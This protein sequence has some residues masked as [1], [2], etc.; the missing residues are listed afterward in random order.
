MINENSLKKLELMRVLEF[1]AEYAQSLTA[2][3]KL[4]NTI[5]ETNVEKVNY[6][7]NQT[8]E[9]CK[10]LNVYNVSPGFNFDSIKEIADKAKILSVLSMKELLCV[11]RILSTSRS[12]YNAFLSIED[13]S[14]VLL[15]QMA[16][17][18]YVNRTIEE[19][20]DFAIL[21]EDEM[22]DRASE[23]LYRIRTAIRKTND[24]VKQKLSS[25]LHSQTMG[26]YLQDSLITMR[27]QRYVI[28]VKTEY[29]AN[30][31]GLIHDQS[32]S[33]AT[34]FIEPMAIVNL[35]N[36][37]K[38][39]FMA[40][41]EEIERILQRFT[42]EISPFAGRLE[43]NECLLAD[44]DAVFSKAKYANEIKG[45][46]P[47]IND[48]G[49]INLKNARHPLIDKTKVVPISVRLGDG[50]NILLIT[51]P[52]TGGKTVSLKT[53]GLF[54]LMAGCGMMLPCYDESEISV[55]ED[56]FCDI[57]DEQSIEQ[58]LSTFSGHITNISKIVKSLSNKTLVLL[59]E[60]GAGTEPNEGAAIAL[61]VTEYILKSNAKAIITT[62]YSQ[63]KEYSLITPN[64]ENASMEFDPKT[65]APT[66]KLIIGVPGSSN[67]IEIAARLG[68]NKDIIQAA[69]GKISDE[70]ISF[71]NVLR[72][73]ESIR[74]EYEKA[75][76]EIE[77]IKASLSEELKKAKNKNEALAKDRENLLYSSKVEAKR[78]I[79][80]AQEEAKE[81]IDEIKEI[82]KRA[83]FAEEQDLFKARSFAK[84]IG[85]LKYGIEKDIDKESEEILYGEK[86][87]VNKLNIG[88]RVY[89][90]PL[91]NIGTVTE[92]K[93]N[94]KISVKIGK[95]NSFVKATDLYHCV[96]N[97][98]SQTFK[99]LGRSSVA[100][101]TAIIPKE[102]NLLGKNVDEAIMELDPFIDAARTERYEDVRVI[103]GM[104]T[105]A[106]RAGLHKY[107]KTDKRIASFRLG[108]YGEGE[109]G[110]TIVTLK[111]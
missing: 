80:S 24:E 46:L 81:L 48:R 33:G 67:A 18:I 71:E 4:L 102:I 49:F 53:V 27:E 96:E 92:I 103:H 68:L 69:R 58:S 3:N 76:D 6:L 35:N 110:V 52:N 93:K 94:D 111:Y 7:L 83:S 100:I 82:K 109:T 87:D 86:I 99:P 50:Y 38:E 62:H 59:D 9:A 91:K 79:S 41:R 2:K 45:T 98:P 23:E 22:N 66:Y 72:Q 78:I 17:M 28:P 5:P 51:G 47:N 39:L 65:F 34:V 26:K 42:Q 40:E 55:F 56:I 70:K 77:L 89:V 32:A 74:Q 15:K 75:K 19:D 54:S 37:L 14:I 108:K 104:G 61:A 106:L 13:E 43:E 44:L 97:L 60:I 30:V 36:K 84:K 85:E 73:A 29:K 88:D 8:N 57:G 11:K 95:I 25:Y 105:G 16:S 1:A 31:P 10:I 12:V 64:I 101:K 90:L 107:F 20:I 21:S 63:L